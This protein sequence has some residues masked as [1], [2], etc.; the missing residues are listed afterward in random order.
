MKNFYLFLIIL[1]V[2]IG[3]KKDEASIFIPKNYLEEFQ[4]EKTQFFDL[5]TLSLKLIKGK[6]GTEIYF[7]REDFDISKDEKITLELIEL[8][9]F[10][11]I[12]YKN[13]N[14]ITKDNELLETNGVLYISFKSDGKEIKL[15]KNKKIRISP[16]KGKLKDNDIFRAK[17]DSLNNIKWEKINQEYV[18]IK[19]DRGGGITMDIHIHKDSIKNYRK[20]VKER[21]INFNNLRK[22]NVND[23]FFI[24]NNDFGWINIDKIVDVDFKMNFNLIDKKNEFLGFNIYFTYKNLKSF[25]YNPRLKNELKFDS[26]P[27]S[28]KTWMT[29]IGEKNNILFYDKIELKKEL[30]NS[31]LILKM[32]KTNKKELQKLLNN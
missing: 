3:C 17:K 12:L 7:M 14:T 28:G 22:S 23:L 1:L 18:V 20:K 27:I 29:I 21:Q 13:I 32:K 25:I 9:D 31:D 2:T 24:T 8:Y 15:K 26:I 30:N 11:E 5:D 4:T 10:K 6:E 16:I 19:E